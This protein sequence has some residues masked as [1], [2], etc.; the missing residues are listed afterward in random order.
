MY[1]IYLA[2]H[3]HYDA[4]W[5]FTKEDYLYINIEQILKQAV[6]LIKKTDYRFLIE[7][8]VLLEEV[9][10]RNP[11]LFIELTKFIKQGKIEIAPG[12]Y[13][14]ADT[15]IPGGETLVRSILFGKRY[16]NEKFGVDIQVM[17]GADSFGFNAQLPQIYRSSGYK[18]FA[19]RRGVSEDKPSEFWWQGL[20]GT[21]LLTHWMPLGYRAGLDIF[22]LETSFDK[23]KEAAATTYILMPSGSGSVPPQ[24]LTSRR[25]KKWNRTHHDSE[26]RITGP[27]DFFRGLEGEASKLEVRKGELYSGKYSQVFPNT[28]SSRM[29]IKQD[30]RKYEHM[31]LSCE[32]WVTV[33]WLLG[34]PYPV[35]EFRDNWKKVLWGAF[36]DVI[37]G[38]GMDEG[39][40]EAKENFAYLQVHMSQILNDFLNTIAKNLRMPEDIIV[41]NP[42]SWSVRNWVEVDLVFERGRIKR[43]GGLKS[44]AEE[45]DIEI[46]EFS[47]YKDGSFQTAKLGFVADVP[48]FGF[49]TYKILFRRIHKTQIGQHLKVAGDAIENRF[50]KIV[51]DPS[52]GLI[53]VYHNGKRLAGGNELMVE[54]E[55]GDLYYHHQNLEQAFK[56][57]ND[58]G[59]T[60]GK[61][62]LK[63]FKISK[64]P[65]RCVIDIE[66]EYYSMVWPYR[67]LDKLRPVLWRHNFISISKKI[68]VYKDI[69]RIDFFTTVNNR[70]PQMRMRVRFDS[71]V[72]SSKYQ[73]EIQFGVVSRRVNRKLDPRDKWV[74]KPCGIYPALNWIDYSD[75]ERGITIIN[76]GIP[77]H[78]IR[79]D[80][81]YLTLLRSVHM[82]STDGDTGP[83]IPTPDAQEFRT[84]TF[85]YAL[86]PHEKDW[87]ESKAFKQAHEFNSNLMGFQLPSVK[88][89]KTFSSH[90]SFVEI[91]PDN[92]IL[93]AFKK[94]ES[95][96]D[97]ILR[98][99]ETKGES[100]NGEILFFKEPLFVKRANLLEEDEQEIQFQGK[101]I[102]LRVRAFE[103]VTLKIRF[104]QQ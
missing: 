93:V 74:E 20:D 86:F 94:A 87:K 83:A 63:K 53:D 68:I 47:L 78:E 77:A 22:N 29:W 9:E 30:M 37:P 40:K 61:F 79:D 58:Q 11:N 44:G 69:P 18:Y 60:F 36:H 8:T 4:V 6:D 48:P 98:F 7:Q 67:F 71:D 21:K 88:S 10:R 66:S 75:R 70:H 38:T 57:E 54:E 23:L 92:L 90:T 26:M 49:R 82:L 89:T 35:D 46:L 27:T 80:A 17:W 14:M 91:R 59:V 1:K 102:K 72:H 73:A 76:R 33:A 28:C 31:I 32:K 34:V 24:P 25:V 15:M 85:E 45:I 100:T 42:L 3:S 51:V 104:G 56:T 13:L 12:E 64:T 96:N 97:V 65:L 55:T 5:A 103:I 99:Y 84:Y 39:Y 41:F 16:V 52:N 95:S 101:I 19:F 81:I 50:F 2:P 43:I 62:G